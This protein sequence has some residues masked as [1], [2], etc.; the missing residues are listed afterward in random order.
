LRLSVPLLIAAVAALAV[1]S[2]QGAKP[3]STLGFSGNHDLGL[4]TSASTEPQTLTLEF[5]GKGNT[6]VLATGLTMGPIPGTEDDFYSGF[7]IG[8]DTC[9]GKTLSARARTCTISVTYTHHSPPG[10]DYGVLT[11]T[12]RSLTTSIEIHAESAA[13]NL[14]PQVPYGL[15]FY[16]NAGTAKAFTLRGTDPDVGDVLTFEIVQ[17]PTHGTFGAISTP[18][19]CSGTPRTCTVD[20]T[21][22]PTAGYVG[23][24]RFQ[25]RADD[26]KAYSNAAWADITVSPAVVG[27]EPWADPKSRSYNMNQTT[28]LTLTGGDPNGD[29]L[30][31]Q[32]V[33]SVAHGSLSAPASVSCS[34]GVPSICQAT[35]GYT[36][37]LGFYGADSFTYRT[38]DGEN[39]SV[40]Q[41][42]TLYA[43]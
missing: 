32:I 39:Y 30:S 12:G 13:P 28:T 7:A 34:P 25:F 1:A 41:T 19:S 43:S 21:Y 40:A 23:P 24:D 26:G 37:P 3:I 33:T 27:D 15:A 6:G 2:A 17:Q 36:P 4:I 5:T 14:Y 18:S 8:T 38:Y 9:D 22:T 11:A 20:V 42:F 16:A 35:V 10:I 31:F 29:P